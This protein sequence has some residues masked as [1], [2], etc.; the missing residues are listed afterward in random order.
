MELLGIFLLVVLAGFSMIALFGA[1][2]LLFPARVEKTQ[3]NL[4]NNLGRSLLLGL[5]NFVFFVVLIATFSWLS[6]QTGQFFGGIFLFLSG[7]ILL[8]LVIFTLLGLTAF[9]KF[10][11]DRMGEGRNRQTKDATESKNSKPSRGVFLASKTR[12]SDCGS[13]K[14]VLCSAAASRR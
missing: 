7:V 3:L 6:Q 9:A 14:F 1:I 4:E 12:L 13:A 5:V 2:A 8:W 11:G 10:F